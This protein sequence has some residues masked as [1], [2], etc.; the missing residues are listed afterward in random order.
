MF[1]CNNFVLWYNHGISS[2]KGDLS[3]LD[4][5]SHILPEIDD[6]AQNI[7]ESIAMLTMLKEQGCEAVALTSHYIAMDESPDEFLQRRA[8]SYA[9]LN[10]EI[11]KLDEDFPKL[12]LGAEVYYYPNICKM[13]EL[14]SLT[15]EGTNLL[16]LEMPMAPWGEYTIREIEE[17]QNSS[18]I[19]VVIAH[20]ERCMGYQKKSTIDRLLYAGVLLQVNASFFI[21]RSTKRK[22]LKLFKEGKITFL[23]SDCHSTKHRPPRLNEALDVIKEKFSDETV[24]EFIS[25]Q[26]SYLNP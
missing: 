22:A 13:E 10:A 24:D 16:L 1:T 25:E 14:S 15:L 9:K 8:E 19:T 4:F 7:D 21:S 2:M 26:L 18:Q 11:K 17:L 12:L 3:V 20:I 5:H 23:G 6:G